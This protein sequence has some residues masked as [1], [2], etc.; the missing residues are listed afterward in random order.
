MSIS[1]R[2]LFIELDT[3]QDADRAVR[4]LHDYPFDKKHRFTVIRFTE[5]ERYAHVPDTFAP[6]TLE[7]YKPRGHLKSWLADSQSRDQMILYQGEDVKVAWHGRNGV[8]EVAHKRT[9]GGI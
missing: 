6:P 8:P 2:Y 5:V 4:N 9:V 1:F 3:P 7:E